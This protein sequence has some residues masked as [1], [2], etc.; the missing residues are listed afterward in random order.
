MAEPDYIVCLAADPPLRSTTVY[1]TGSMWSN[2]IHHAFR[3][4]TIA[5]ASAHCA[6]ADGAY[7]REH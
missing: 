3:F 6:K 2:N 4:P 5:A 7:W 1:W